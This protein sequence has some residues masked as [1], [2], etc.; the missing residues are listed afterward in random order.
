LTTNIYKRCTSSWTWLWNG[1]IDI[2]NNENGESKADRSRLHCPSLMEK[3]SSS[4][5]VTERLAAQLNRTLGRRNKQIEKLRSP[6][7]QARSY[8]PSGFG[9]TGD[10][11]RKPW[12][13]IFSQK[14]RYNE[15]LHFCYLLLCYSCTEY[16]FLL[17]RLVNFP[18]LQTI[19]HHFGSRLKEY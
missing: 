5:K 2:Q 3:L 13:I 16:G 12:K 1:W 4:R 11:S 9:Q 6:L 10:E 14:R 18:T 19:R 8:E 7:S 15:Q 17:S